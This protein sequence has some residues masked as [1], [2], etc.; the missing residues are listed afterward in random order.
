[1]IDGDLS[2]IGIVLEDH[3]DDSDDQA[4]SNYDDVVEISNYNDE[5][6]NSKLI[7]LILFSNMY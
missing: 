4:A 3:P 1:M 6:A 2:N 5:T 7:S